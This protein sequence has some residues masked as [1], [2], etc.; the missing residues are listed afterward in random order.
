MKNQVYIAAVSLFF[1]VIFLNMFIANI[2][3]NNIYYDY[4]L[5]SYNFKQL[6]LFVLSFISGFTLI[7]ALGG[8]VYGEE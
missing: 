7:I 4:D 2:N 5:I 8:L 6:G 3:D 1:S